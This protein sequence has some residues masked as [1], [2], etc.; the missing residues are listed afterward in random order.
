MEAARNLSSVLFAFKT[1]RSPD[2]ED[3]QYVFA[4]HL[5]VVLTDLSDEN[6][7][8][9]LSE[10]K[11]VEII[12]KGIYQFNRYKAIKFSKLFNT[13]RKDRSQV[14][15][16]MHLPFEQHGPK[17]GPCVE[18]KDLPEFY[19]LKGKVNQ[20][21]TITEPMFHVIRWM[22]YWQCINWL[23]QIVYFSI[24]FICSAN[25]STNSH[26]TMNFTC[27]VSD[28]RTIR[29]FKR[30]IFDCFNPDDKISLEKF[31]LCL[32]RE[33]NRLLSE[34]FLFRQSKN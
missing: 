33:A 32:T 22:E 24:Q 30:V 3:V 23:I 17:S 2:P 25:K 4:Q 1:A 11:N 18:A 6:A 15:Y 34:F 5:E 12:T 13:W 14:Y 21:L 16:Y 8:M 27:S 26:L 28:K 9:V 31:A 19:Q 7:T 20:W 10:E 29:W